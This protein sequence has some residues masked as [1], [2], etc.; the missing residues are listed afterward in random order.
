ME[1]PIK[2]LS[3]VKRMPFTLVVAMR[4][5]VLIPIFGVSVLMII[6]GIMGL[7]EGD[8]IELPTLLLGIAFFVISSYFLL[9][10]F[11]LEK[12]RLSQLQY[13][14]YPDRLVIYN[15]VTNQIIHDLSFDDFPSFT[16]RENLNNFGYIIIGKEEPVMTRGGI[17]GQNYGINM[18]DP[19]IMLENLPE[20]KKEYLFLKELV[21]AYQE[22]HHTIS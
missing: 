17:F 6:T 13:L 20:V 5:L 9:K 2:T 4:L 15:L 19:D 7:Y 21:E 1:Q 11:V 12:I 18:K 16:F 3:P 14:F 8:I 22:K 10:I